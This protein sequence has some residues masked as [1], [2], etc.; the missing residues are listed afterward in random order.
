MSKI[1]RSTKYG[2]EL[3]LPTGWQGPGFL[4][5]L[6]DDH[7]FKGSNGQG[8]SISVEKNPSQYSSGFD[9]V[10]NDLL[11]LVK[12]RGACL[13]DVFDAVQNSNEGKDTFILID[14]KRH[15]AVEFRL[16][17]D[18]VWFKEY[19]VFVGGKSFHINAHSRTK[20]FTMI[21]SILETFRVN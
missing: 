21:D 20:E 9:N 16:Q 5:S 17:E 6:A 19:A 15:P 7:R 11:G 3:H 12:F 8:F 18:G 14:G 13:M 10:W 1:Y 2:F 4:M